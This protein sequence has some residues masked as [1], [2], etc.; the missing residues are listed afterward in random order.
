MVQTKLDINNIDNGGA[1]AQRG[2]NYQDAIAMLIII[3]NFAK[4]DFC[5][6][7]EC[8]DDLEVDLPK[9]KIFIQV[10]STQQSVASLVR[11]YKKQ[12]GT[13]NKS[14]LYKSL[15][16]SSVNQLNKYKIVTTSYTDGV[17]TVQGEIFRELY[18]YTDEQK[19]LIIEKLQQQGLKKE[20]LEQ[21]LQNSYIYV[22]PFV[23][24]LDIAIKYLLGVMAEEGISIDNN[25]GKLL[26]CELLTDIHKKSEKKIMSPNDIEKKKL[27]KEELIKLARVEKC[28]KYMEEIVTKLDNAGI[29][30][31]DDKIIINEHIRVV[32]LKHKYEYKIIEDTGINSELSGNPVNAIKTLHDKLKFLNINSNLLYAI[33]IDKYVMNALYKE[34]I[35]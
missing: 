30:N 7:L 29:I 23:D 19:K 4:D 10:K 3:T 33:L 27:K 12:D 17:S 11:Q 15:N 28:Y 34:N 2:F 22:S 32:D 31:F 18:Q 25:R 20:D 9:Q 21:K 26:L 6:Y 14:T 35:N 24:N 16:K 8:K 13:Y 1:N 5:I